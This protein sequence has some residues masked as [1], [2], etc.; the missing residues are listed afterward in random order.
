MGSALAENFPVQ[1]ARE[2]LVIVGEKFAADTMMKMFTS[3]PDSS[4][5]L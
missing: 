4:V 1:C 2:N 3:L 5:S